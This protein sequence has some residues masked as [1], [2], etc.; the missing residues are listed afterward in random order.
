MPHFN[1]KHNKGEMMMKKTAISIILSSLIVGALHAETISLPGAT[2]EVNTDKDTTTQKTEVINFKLTFKKGWTLF[3]IPGYKAY[4]AQDLFG[5][6]DYVEKIFYYDNTSSAWQ[7]FDPENSDDN[8]SM[9]AP[10][11]GYWVYSTQAFVVEFKTNA[12]SKADVYEKAAVRLTKTANSGTEDS[13][14][15]PPVPINTAGYDDTWND[16]GG[17]SDDFIALPGVANW[18]TKTTSDLEQYS[19]SAWNSKVQFDMDMLVDSGFKGSSG[20][21]YRFRPTGYNALSVTMETSSGS[22][23][24]GRASIDDTTGN[25]KIEVS[26]KDPIKYELLDIDE[27][28]TSISLKLKNTTT[29]KPNL[30]QLVEIYNEDTEKWVDALAFFEKDYSEDD[31]ELSG[32]DWENLGDDEDDA[33]DF[34]DEGYVPTCPSTGEPLPARADGT[35]PFP[36]DADWPSDCPLDFEYEYTEGEDVA[37]D[38]A[39]C[40]LPV[41]ATTFAAD[42]TPTL[43]FTYGLYDEYQLAKYFSFTKDCYATF[44]FYWDEGNPDPDGRSNHWPEGISFDNGS[45]ILEGNPF[46]KSEIGKT[47]AAK[48]QLCNPKGCVGRDFN[49]IIK[50]NA[51][52]SDDGSTTNCA[53]PT[54]TGGD[55]NLEFAYGEFNEHFFAGHFQATEDCPILNYGFVW[56]GGNPDPTSAGNSWIE[57][58]A[59]SNADGVLEGIPFESS[60]IGET[61]GATVSACNKGGC[62][63]INTEITVVDGDGM[64]EDDAEDDAVMF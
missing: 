45:G 8:A 27:G 9:L 64:T 53:A 63:Q 28:D 25:L 36:E 5:D 26:G 2:I 20:T 37:I 57:G 31:E 23:V 54:T 55:S 52:A 17:V 60:E 40:T 1:N 39:T 12:P 10:G 18:N 16:N 35:Y 43:T 62:T 51:S 59:F 41:L 33:L 7:T 22:S 48:L 30:W 4:K 34:I 50:G 24:A 21:L 19:E 15:F 11:V 44:G 13:N 6:T 49:V 56:D 58:I 61:F 46:E 3:G 32:V 47:F 29:D 42:V 14:L 38:S